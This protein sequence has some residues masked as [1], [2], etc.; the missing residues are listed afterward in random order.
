MKFNPLNSTDS[1][2]N[3]R[4]LVIAKLSKLK[5]FNRTPIL[6]GERKGSEIDY[7]KKFGQDWL[8]INSAPT[9]HYK[10]S[11]MKEFISMHPS[12][13]LL[14]EKYG[15]AEKSEVTLQDESLKSSLI[16]VNIKDEFSGEVKRKKL[17]LTSDLQMIKL[18]F[19]KLFKYKNS[20]SAGISL[21]YTS[22]KYPGERFELDNELRTLDFYSIENEDTIVL[23]R[24]R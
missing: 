22:A 24:N 3:I 19:L 1:L 8:D 10:D 16:W 23:T 5:M 12:Y 7:L 2:E 14:V 20:A 6:P 18:V 13:L 21:S 4:Q 9:D 11:R 15:A 17:P